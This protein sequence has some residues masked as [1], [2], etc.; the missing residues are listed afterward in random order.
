MAGSMTPNYCCK[1]NNVHKDLE[2]IAA[3]LI[4]HIKILKY[5]SSSLQDQAPYLLEQA[6][7]GSW[8]YDLFTNW[9]TPLVKEKYVFISIGLALLWHYKQKHCLFIFFYLILLMKQSVQPPNLRKNKNQ[10]QF[11][12]FKLCILLVHFWL[13]QSLIQPTSTLTPGSI[14]YFPAI[15][16]VFT[17]LRRKSNLLM[18]KENLLTIFLSCLHS[19]FLSSYFFKKITVLSGDLTQSPSWALLMSYNFFAYHFLMLPLKIFLKKLLIFPSVFNPSSQKFL[20]KAWKF[21]YDGLG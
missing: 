20:Q 13:L 6:V 1:A 11:Y 15:W 14:L 9:P 10:L 2:I 3:K 16:T 17:L 4:M 12:F 7:F 21:M 5:F 19:Y 8:G 18:N